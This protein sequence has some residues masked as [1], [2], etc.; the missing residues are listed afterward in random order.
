MTFFLIHFE[1]ERERERAREKQRERE[2]ERESQ[3]GS[4]ASAPEQ[5]MG[6]ELMNHKIMTPAETKSR[7]LNPLSHPGAPPLMTLGYA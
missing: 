4:V 6:L 1:R 3:A 5:D 7:V 2:K